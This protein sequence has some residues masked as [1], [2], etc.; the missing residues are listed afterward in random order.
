MPERFGLSVKL[1]AAFLTASAVTFAI[2]LLALERATTESFRSYLSHAQ[3]MQSMMGDAGSSM[4]PGERQFI[5]RLRLSLVLAGVGGAALATAMGVFIARRIAAPLRALR[6]A[7]HAVAAGDTSRRV[8]VE[9]DDEI[10]DLARSFNQMAATL[11]DQ[12]R[13]R[14]QFI[15]DVAH[16]LRTPLAVLQAEIEALQDGVTRPTRERLASLHEETLVLGRLV[17]DLRTLSLADAGELRLT[18]TRQPAAALI[19]RAALT[20]ADQA[21]RAGVTLNL[22]LSPGLPDVEADADRLTQVLMNLLSNA[23]RHTPAGGEVSVSAEVR[24]GAIRVAVRDT[25]PGIP[26]SA[27]P[28]VFD[29]FYRVDAGRS[30][31]TGGSGLGLAIARQLVRAHGGEL[32]AETSA[33]GATF[34]FTLPAAPAGQSADAR[35]RGDSGGSRS[36]GARGGGAGSDS[37]NGTPASTGARQRPVPSRTSGRGAAQEGRP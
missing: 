9:A 15:A 5:D 22:S 14:Q 21:A 37:E 35:M 1:V 19:E 6:E 11:A 17:E 36:V 10:G 34:I 23:I 29:R 24:D 12:E 30:R 18:R 2:V 4:G 26:A 20:M 27:L 16:E 32:W 28:H 33:R 8:S 13:L 25:G 3:A 7:A 31:Q